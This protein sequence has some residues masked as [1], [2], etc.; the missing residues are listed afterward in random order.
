MASNRPARTSNVAALILVL[1]GTTGLVALGVYVRHSPPL[2]KPRESATPPPLTPAPTTESTKREITAT[3]F[4]PSISGDNLELTARQTTVPDG[5]D[6]I[7]FVVNAYLLE[8]KVTPTDARALSSQIR[9][10]VAY[11]DFTPSFAQTYGSIDERTLLRGICSSIG[12]FPDVSKVQFQV[13]G[14]PMDTLGNVDLSQP[15][16]VIRDPNAPDPAEK[17]GNNPPR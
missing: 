13:E 2:T 12:Q 9:N 17:T 11:L 5:Q 16:D 3:V 8:A 4:T 10:G 15:I 7:V 14:K 6:P 1:L